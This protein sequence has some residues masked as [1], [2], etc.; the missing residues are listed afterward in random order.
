MRAMQERRPRKGAL[1][2]A[3]LPALAEER[4]W[5][6]LGDPLLELLGCE[7]DELL[8]AGGERGDTRLDRERDDMVDAFAVLA[9]ALR[10]AAAGFPLRGAL[11][12]GRGRR[13]L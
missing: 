7:H 1:L 3:A 9:L 13:R 2:T 4:G 6:A 8:P 11:L 5:K 12:R 10:R